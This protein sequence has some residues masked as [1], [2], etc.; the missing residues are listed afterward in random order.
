MPGVTPKAVGGIMDKLKEGILSRF[1]KGETSSIKR[2]GDFTELEEY[3]A[4]TLT[5]YEDPADGKRYYKIAIQPGKDV[6]KLKRMPKELVFVIDCS[7]SIQK[8]RLEEFKEGIL[9]CLKNLNPGDVF[10]IMA[11]KENVIWFKPDSVKPDPQIIKEAMDFVEGLTAGEGTDAY[12]ALL[13]VIQVKASIIPS[14]IIMF[15]DGRPT[16]GITD[17]RRI[18]NEI[19]RTKHLII[20]KNTLL[21]TIENKIIAN[22]REIPGEN[23]SLNSPE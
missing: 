5:T 17:S 13:E 15:S 1:T 11:F 20:L 18:V 16:Y 22:S 9:Y 12:K 19:A 8:E 7:L 3:L 14:Y 23:V 2:I 4:Y 21:N 6:E 10:N